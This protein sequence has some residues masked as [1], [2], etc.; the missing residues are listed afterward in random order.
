MRILLQKKALCKQ[1]TLHDDM[2]VDLELL[3][4]VWKNRILNRRMHGKTIS[5]DY[6]DVKFQQTLILCLE[7]LRKKIANKALCFCEINEYTLQQKTGIA[8]C[9]SNIACI[10][11]LD[12]PSKSNNLVIFCKELKFK[13]DK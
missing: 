9:A 7:I 3:V 2:I 4:I 10:S 5:R 13:F 8:L 12:L 1:I 11:R 6:A